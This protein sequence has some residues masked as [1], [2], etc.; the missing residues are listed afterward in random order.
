MKFEFEIV[1]KLIVGQ[2]EL[3]VYSK[4]WLFFWLRWLSKMI[5]MIIN[6]AILISF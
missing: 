3:I 4:N 5:E 1:K 2:I 6:M